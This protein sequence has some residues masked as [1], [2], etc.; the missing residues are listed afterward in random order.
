MPPQVEHIFDATNDKKHHSPLYVLT[1]AN[2]TDLLSKRLKITS[3]FNYKMGI[4]Y[5]FKTNESF[6]KR[7]LPLEESMLNAKVSDKE[8]YP[9]LEQFGLKWPEFDRM[10]NKMYAGEE[11]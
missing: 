3:D 4:V 10:G 8:V 5:L 11:K 2:P 7:F 6:K 9:Y 1:D